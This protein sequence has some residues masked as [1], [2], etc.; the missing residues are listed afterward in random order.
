MARISWGVVGLF[1][2]VI[3][4]V[5]LCGLS[6]DDAHPLVLLDGRQ[7]DSQERLLRMLRAAQGQ[8]QEDKTTREHG[9]VLGSQVRRSLMRL[10][11]SLEGELSSVKHILNKA[12]EGQKRELQH[13]AD[14]RMSNTYER[15]AARLSK[16]E[17][18]GDEDEDEEEWK[19]KEMQRGALR[20][21]SV[22]DQLI[23]ALKHDEDKQLV[24]RTDWHS[25]EALMKEIETAAYVA[26]HLL[27]DI[28][29]IVEEHGGAAHETD[30]QG[31]QGQRQKVLQQ[32]QASA[33][34]GQAQAQAQEHAQAQAGGGHHGAKVVKVEKISFRRKE[35]GLT[36][37]QVLPQHLLKTALLSVGASGKKTF[38]LPQK[39]LLMI[40]KLSTRFDCF[41]ACFPSFPRLPPPPIAHL[42]L[43]GVMF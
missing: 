30:G 34:S 28:S 32:Q 21:E 36:V 39:I 17:K 16:F 1:V 38:V 12:G 14:S 5:A 19:R 43:S 40:S 13:G 8:R 7:A 9:K 27:P 11:H 23:K 22:R 37:E 15:P 3:A 4:V 29:K 25:K 24:N 10:E 31:A 42:I 2:F 41:L 33:D 6:D 20:G 18:K 35:G 26:V